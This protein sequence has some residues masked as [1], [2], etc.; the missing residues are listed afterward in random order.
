MS[1]PREIDPSEIAVLSA[2]GWTDKEIAENFKISPSTVY[3]AKKAIGATKKHARIELPWKLAEKHRRTTP[4]LYIEQIEKSKQG[5]KTVPTRYNAA[6]RMFENAVEAGLDLDYDP[7]Y[8]GEEVSPYGGFK[9]VKA[10]ESNWYIK[11]LLE[12]TP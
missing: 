9:W 2:Q 1:R 11:K 3:R 8:A 6:K 10:N 12:D 7:E 4:H 5:L